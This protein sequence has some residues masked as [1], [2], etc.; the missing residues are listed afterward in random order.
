MA[1]GA[2]VWDS[3][4]GLSDL[5]WVLVS[6]LAPIWGKCLGLTGYQ[7]PHFKNENHVVQTPVIPEHRAR[8]FSL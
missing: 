1:G 4:E 7:F 2:R 8:A 5:T 3:Q 6:N